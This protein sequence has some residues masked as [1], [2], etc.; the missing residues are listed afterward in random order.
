[1]WPDARVGCVAQVIAI[2]GFG[3]VMFLVEGVWGGNEAYAAL[4]AGVYF[5]FVSIS[6]FGYGAAWPLPVR[7]QTRPDGRARARQATSPHARSWAA[8]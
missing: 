2:F 3:L 7:R 6:T 5:S 4:D 8:C 1:M